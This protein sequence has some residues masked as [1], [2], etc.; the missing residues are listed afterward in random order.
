MTISEL[1]PFESC[2]VLKEL[3]LA[4]L[5]SKLV[6]GMICMEYT[7]G[8]DNDI[9]YPILCLLL[10]KGLHGFQVAERAL[11]MWN[12]DRVISLVSQNWQAVMPLILPALERNIRSHWNQAVLNL[13]QNI[14]KL[15]YEMDEELFLACKKKF[16][17]EEVKQDLMEK[18]RMAWEHPESTVVFKPVTRNVAVQVRPVIAPPIVAALS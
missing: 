14:K 3:F 4:L 17:E 5:F 11:L 1:N 18:Q 15:L 2:L 16:E 10:Q 9:Q 13:T 7:F 12:N 6:L 8:D